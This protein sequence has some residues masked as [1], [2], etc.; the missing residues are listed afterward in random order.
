MV[1]GIGHSYTKKGEKKRDGTTIWRCTV[2]PK[3]NPCKGMVSSRQGIFT[4]FVLHSCEV[5]NNIEVKAAVVAEAK[6]KALDSIYESASKILEPI[7]IDQLEKKGSK[8]MLPDPKLVARCMNRVRQS[9]RPPNPTHLFFPLHRKFIPEVDS[10][11]SS[12][13]NINQS[14]KT[15]N[16]ISYVLT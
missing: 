4:L 16:R 10:C 14:V 2:R 8:V 3:K 6:T 7:L 1:D 13:V 12:F 5:K 11:I 9:A 15:F